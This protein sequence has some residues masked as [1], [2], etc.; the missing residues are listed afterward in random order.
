MY[1]S[2][3]LDSEM[4]RIT[5]VHFESNMNDSL[6]SGEKAPMGHWWCGGRGG[7]RGERMHEGG[8]SAKTVQCLNVYAVYAQRRHYTGS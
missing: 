3:V 6:E 4:Q 5:E 2:R 8:G 1:S 7:R